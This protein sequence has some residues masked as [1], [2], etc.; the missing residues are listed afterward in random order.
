M[1][2]KTKKTT[3]EI[4]PKPRSKCR[5]IPKIQVSEAKTDEIKCLEHKVDEVTELL[6]NNVKNL[7]EERTVRLETLETNSLSLQ[8]Q[9]SQFEEHTIK[10]KNRNI[11][12]DRCWGIFYCKCCCRHEN[13]CT[14]FAYCVCCISTERS[15]TKRRTIKEQPRSTKM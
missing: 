3:K 14:K 12:K 5:E 2:N 7:L 9:A 8:Y 4:N 15:K 1:K 10:I 6:S 11:L 13:C